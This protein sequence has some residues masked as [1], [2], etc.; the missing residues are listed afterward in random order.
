V[1]QAD[2]IVVLGGGRVLDVGRHSELLTRNAIYTQMVEL[3]FGESAIPT[4]VRST[5]ATR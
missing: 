5:V 1:L 2:K 3:Q 4:K